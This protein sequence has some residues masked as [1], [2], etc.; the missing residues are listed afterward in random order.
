M[1]ESLQAFQPRGVVG[2]AQLGL[3]LPTCSPLTL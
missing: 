1:E 2:E 3:S